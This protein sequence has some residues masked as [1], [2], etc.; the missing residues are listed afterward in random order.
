MTEGAVRVAVHRLR[1]RFG[2]LLCA[3]IADTVAT[4]A[5][6]GDELRYLIS[7]IRGGLEISGNLA[8][9]TL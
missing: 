6:V 9:K 5:E 2:E 4:P 8:A 1:Q 7:V 3:E